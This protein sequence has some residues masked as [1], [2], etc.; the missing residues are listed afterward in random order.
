MNFL[1]HLYLSGDDQEIRIGNF[2]ADGIRGK[3][4]SAY[5][6]KIQQ[7]I[8]L[9]RAIDTFTDQHPIF[10][11]HCKLLSPDHGHYS[12]VIMDVVYDHFLAAHWKE[13]H[14]QSLS[15][16]AM[17]FYTE[18]IQKKHL[19]PEKMQKLIQAMEKQNWLVQYKHIAGLENILFHMS[20][21]TSF[22]SNFPSAVGTIQRKQKTMLN[23]F[24]SFFMELQD[25]CQNY[26]Y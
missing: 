22:P 26:S 24:F 6:P 2:I 7:G 5:S 15:D 12:R 1:A 25:H 8:R 4:F 16:F 21:R 23:D 17:Q 11:N 3:N 13:F 20:Q 10:R 9:H 18:A 14:D 19:F